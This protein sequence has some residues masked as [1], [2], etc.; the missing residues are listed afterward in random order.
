MYVVGFVD[1]YEDVGGVRDVDDIGVD[2]DDGGRVDVMIECGVVFAMMM[3]LSMMM[4]LM[5]LAM[6]MMMLVRTMAMM[7][8]SVDGWR[9]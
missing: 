2:V 7:M 3:M 5:L 8:L 6:V 9:F 1:D 4:V